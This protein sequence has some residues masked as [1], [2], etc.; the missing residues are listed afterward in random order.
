VKLKLQKQN[1]KRKRKKLKKTKTKKKKSEDEE[2][3]EEVDEET[4]K[5]I[6]YILEHMKHKTLQNLAKRHKIKANKSHSAL[7]KELIEYYNDNKEKFT[8]LNEFLGRKKRSSSK[9]RINDNLDTS[10]TYKYDE[11]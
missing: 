2:E 9:R 1:Q 6:E 10:V 4:K 3:K 11:E 7:E 8:D 5:S